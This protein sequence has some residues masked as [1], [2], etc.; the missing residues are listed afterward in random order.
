MH[1]KIFNHNS[2]KKNKTIVSKKNLQEKKK[3]LWHYFTKSQKNQEKCQT[4]HLVLLSHFLF[5]KI[6]VII[7]YRIHCNFEIYDEI[8]NDDC[9]TCPFCNFKI[10]EYV[11]NNKEE[12]CCY[13]ME[14]IHDNDTRLCSSCGLVHGN[15]RAE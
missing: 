1:K 3:H 6:N 12:P 2:C 8:K 15:K 4:I 10:E 11:N 14:I 7:F 5:H 13:K 9:L